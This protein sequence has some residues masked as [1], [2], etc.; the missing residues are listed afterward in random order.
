MKTQSFV[1]TDLG[2]GKDVNTDSYLEDAELR[3]FAVA[4]GLGDYSSAEV[5]SALATRLLR[6]YLTE[7]RAILDQFAQDGNDRVRVL[8]ALEDST[9]KAGYAIYRKAQ[10][11]L[12]R[13][14][15][16]T[17]LSVLLLT[18][19]RGFL[20]H[21]GDSRIYILRRGESV[22]LTQDHSLVSDMIRNG[23]L[24][25]GDPQLQAYRDEV[26]RALG[27]YADVQ[28]DT[29]DFELAAGDTFLL[30]TDGLADT[31]GDRRE[32]NDVIDT[33]GLK[34]APR[35][36]INLAR[37][38]GADDNVTA[39]IL[40]VTAERGE[41]SAPDARDI[42][43]KLDVL[44]RMPLFQHLSYVELVEVLNV[45]DVRGFSAGEKIFSEGQVG[46]A[47]YVVLDGLVS[48]RRGGIEL[49]RMGSGGHFGEM[50]IMDKGPRSAEAVAEQDSRLIEVGRRSLFTLMR[51]EKDI[52]VKLLWCF[53]QVLNQRLRATNEDLLKARGHLDAAAPLPDLDTFE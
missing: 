29:R 6:E 25:K 24:K 47:V 13:R 1:H 27:I 17:T 53:V 11:D 52:A 38:R 41:L 22:Q 12:S 23:R 33:H 48:I 10:E 31:L 37:A 19:S 46:D 16:G 34:A 28:V 49:I 18:P 51:K 30:C 4:D 14:G 21:V 44:K 8:K 5:A 26:T 9:R 35:A 20:A 32:I 45:S 39:L 40:R 43:D 36:F 15:M 2:P 3:V 42:S 50:A 7:H